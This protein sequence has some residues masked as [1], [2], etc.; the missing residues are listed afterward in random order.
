MVAGL[1]AIP[2]LATPASASTVGTARPG[3]GCD[4][5]RPAVAHY[6]GGVLVKAA[7]GGRDAD[8]AAAQQNAA[9]A[10]IPCAVVVGPSTETANIGVTANGTVFYAPLASFTSLPVAPATPSM[11]A[12][13]TDNG[14]NWDVLDPA[15]TPEHNTLV[16][17]LDVDPQTSRVWYATLGQD[18]STCPSG[19]FAHISWSDDDGKTWHNPAE[20]DCR[21]LQGGMSVVEGPAPAGSPKPVGYPHVIYQCGNVTDGASPLSVH[22]WKSLD[23]GDTWSYVAGPNN[24]ANCADERPRGRAVGPDGTF[25]MSIQ[26]DG[27][28]EIAVS[29]NEGASWQVRPVAAGSI[30]R[31]DVSS[32]T[33]DKAGNVYIVWVAGGTGG[34]A[35]VPALGRPYM[36]VSPNGGITWSKPVVVSAPG[37][38]DVTED[39]VTAGTRGHVA[40]SYLGTTDGENFDGYV[41]ESWQANEANPVFWSAPVNN[42]GQPLMTGAVATSA[43]HGDRMWFITVA[44]GPGGTPWTAFHCAGTTACPLRDGVAGRLVGQPASRR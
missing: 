30:D 19:T 6:A 39:A 43:V 41:T 23:G 10:P 20:Q 26:C 13:S 9:R 35:G 3:P 14:A 33:T 4:P 38:K 11:V 5:A 42:P 44:F 18:A 25:Y 21:Q 40:I 15:S 34:A 2:V 8:P 37:V 7:P 16:P 36:T 31:L 1:F 22:C 27:E 29:H 24:A 17:W 32:I 28:L 12:R